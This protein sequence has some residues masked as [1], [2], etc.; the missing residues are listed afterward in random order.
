M[1]N[2]INLARRAVPKRTTLPNGTSFVSNKEI[3]RDIGSQ[4]VLKLVAD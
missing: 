3:K 1:R 2:K 4:G